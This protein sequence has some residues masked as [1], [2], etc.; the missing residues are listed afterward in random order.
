MSTKRSPIPHA[1]HMHGYSI[2]HDGHTVFSLNIVSPLR[3]QQM[4]SVSKQH[5][6]A[7]YYT[8][9]FSKP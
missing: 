3:T 4:D 1:I 6:F 9:V 7:K 8:T 2:G 5:K